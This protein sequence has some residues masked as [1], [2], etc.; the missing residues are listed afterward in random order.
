[1]HAF[2]ESK[3]QDLKY[4]ETAS[5]SWRKVTGL[6]QLVHEWVMLGL[7]WEPCPAAVAAMEAN[8]MEEAM[9]PGIRV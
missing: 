3:L 2:A 1:M 6:L 8:M 9:S 5:I 4:L 7:S